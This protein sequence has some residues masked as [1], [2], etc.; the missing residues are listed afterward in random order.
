ME[1]LMILNLPPDTLKGSSIPFG[2]ARRDREIA[3]GT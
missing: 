2:L 1:M 3:A